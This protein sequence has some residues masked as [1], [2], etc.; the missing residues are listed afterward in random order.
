MRLIEFFLTQLARL[1]LWRYRPKIVA[2]TGNVGKT[3]AKE[4]I[5]TVLKNQKHVRAS[6]GNLNTE[7]GVAA[8]IIGDWS[9]EYYDEG[10]GT[11]FWVKVLMTGIL[12]LLAPQKYPEVL[13]LEYAADR[14]GD[15]RKLARKFK[16]D[17][18][19]VTAVGQIPVHVEYF[20]GPEAVAKEKSELVRALDQKG[21][22]VLNFDDLAVLDM[23]DLA[24]GWTVTYGFGGGADFRASNYEIRAGDGGEPSGIGFKINH[25]VG[26]TPIKIG[27][28]LGKSQGYAAA[29]AA[30]VAAVFGI[31]LVSVSEALAQYHG[32]K[33]RLKIIPGIKNSVIIDDTYNAAPLSTHI[34]LETLKDIGNPSRG[35]GQNRK[36]AILGDMLE[37]GQYSVQA[38]QNIGDMAGKIA[39]ILVCVG[40]KAKFIA[41]S[42]ANE[43]PKENIYWFHNSDEAKAKVQELVQEKDVILVK[44]SQ[45]MRM[46]KIVEEV[47]AE[48]ESAGELLVRQSKKWKVK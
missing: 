44:G 12:R 42:A 20:S 31:N 37:L 2:I 17:V 40:E 32:P 22:A 28:I 9:K 43:M 5:A 38:H 48:P 33:G 27:G 18:A 15:I 8:T 21:T 4:A 24:K 6:G 41:D 47:M 13:V 10:G 25:S 30:A 39:N 7:L 29:V 34:A 1:Y 23:K 45:G 35:S 26:F 19:V 16:P 36:I 14:P 46:E 3:S 11:L